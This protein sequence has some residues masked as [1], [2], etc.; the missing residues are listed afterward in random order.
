MRKRS[1]QL[2]KRLLPLSVFCLALAA[3][4][5]APVAY[6]QAGSSSGF[7]FRWDNSRDFR[8]L[9]YFLTLADAEAR[10]DYYL[11]LGPKDRKTALLAGDFGP[12]LFRRQDQS[13][14]RASLHDQAGRHC[15]EDPL[16]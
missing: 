7:E 12:V 13:I 8:K 1:T 3:P 11:V 6:A 10:S 16:S 5:A 2:I 4:L 9:Y 15:L 14:G